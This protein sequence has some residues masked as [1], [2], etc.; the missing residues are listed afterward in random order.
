MVHLTLFGW[1]TGMIAAVN[2]HTM[3]V[4]A[5]RDF[6]STRLIWL[7]L[8]AWLL[9]VALDSAGQLLGWTRGWPLAQLLLICGGAAQVGAATLFALLIGEL[10]VG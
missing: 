5:A 9:G 6:P 7:H 1:I 3:P 2:Y 10:L 8:A 4:F